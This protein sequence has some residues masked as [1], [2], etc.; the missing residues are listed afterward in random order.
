M[1][2]IQI[3][4]GAAFFA[5]VS[6]AAD[7]PHFSREIR[8]IL[9]DNCFKC[10]G[11]DAGQR[12]KDLRLD[13][14]ETAIAKGLIVPGSSA[15]SEL[16]KRITSTDPD[17]HMP[18]PD[19]GLALN[20]SQIAKIV[21]W[22]D[23]GATVEKHWAFVPP[24]E[25]APPSVDDPEHWIRNPIDAFVL[26]RLRDEGLAP[27]ARASSEALLRRVAFDLTGLPPDPQSMDAIAAD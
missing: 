7:G 27:S 9:S 20:E 4:V 2:F 10:H 6:F 24:A 23:A 22:I 14:P 8:P 5:V 1:I 11:P 19:S 12:K 18:P 13:Q 16:V 25:I 17:F 21:A 15:T 3:V 26:K